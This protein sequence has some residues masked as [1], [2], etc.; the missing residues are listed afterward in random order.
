MRFAASRTKGKFYLLSFALLCTG[1]SHAMD[2]K[3]VALRKYEI[4]KTRVM[5]G[6]LSLDWSEFRVAAAVAGVESGFDMQAVRTRVLND[7]DAGNLERAL[8]GAQTVIGHNMAE[9]EG[10][11]LAMTV[12]QKMGRDL[13]ARREHNLVDAIVKSIMSSGDGQ[14]EQKAWMTVSSDEQAFVVDI[15]LDAEA[16]SQ[17]VVRENGHDYDKMTVLAEDGSEHVVWFNTD[18]DSRVAM[19]EMHI[20]AKAM[21]V[22]SARR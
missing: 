4:L 21:P 11:L 6:D 16:K 17:T 15:V 12:Y 22:F 3:A 1:V 19:S 7:V 20:D 13:D 8:A 14:S 18:T 5:G 10:H 2:S 9:P